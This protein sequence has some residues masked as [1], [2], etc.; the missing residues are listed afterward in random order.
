MALRFSVETDDTS[1]TYEIK[2][3]VVTVGR[4]RTSTLFVDDPTLSRTHCQIEIEA[5]EVFVRDLNSRNGTTVNGQKIARQRIKNGDRITIGNT[6]IVFLGP[7]EET[8][9]LADKGATARWTARLFDRKKKKSDAPKSRSQDET[10]E[11]VRRLHR[12]LAINKK[13]AAEVDSSRVLALILDS[14]VDFVN[15]ERGFLVTVDAQGLSIPVARDFWRKDVTGPAFEVSKSIA[16]EVVR[17]GEPLLTENASEDVRLEDMDSVHALQLRSVLCVPLKAQ[18][19]TIG[20][21]Y[22]DNRLT[23]G[24]FS[25]RDVAVLEAFADQAAI[26]L[27]N[28]GKLFRAFE[29]VEKLK[30]QADEKRRESAALR[31]QMRQLEKARGVDADFGAVLGRSPAMREFLGR[32]GDASTG[33]FP[34]LL[35]G[36]SGTGKHLLARGVHA[37]SP[38][39]DGPF[40][41]FS[42]AAP[43]DVV[44]AAVF[45]VEKR[46]GTREEAAGLLE[47]ADGGT[48][49]LFELERLDAD[50]QKRLLRFLESGETRRGGDVK[51]RKVDVRIVLGTSV[52]P[53]E[54]AEEG[55]LRE[56]L[57]LRFKGARHDVPPLRRRQG[58]I[59]VLARAFLAE[60][61]PPVGI[62]PR[63]LKSLAAYSW[64]RNVQELKEELQRAATLCDGVITPRDLAPHIAAPRGDD[65]EGGLKAHI[66]RVERDLIV[67]VLE[68][69]GDNKSQAAQILGLSRLGLRKKMARYGLM[70]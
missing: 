24:S 60:M 66:E 35:V 29:E 26:S 61:D 23:N 3:P 52:D 47:E 10:E 7:T 30:G 9:P 53:E 28:S 34:I 2:R 42:C 22:L 14:A 16:H 59:G 46:G 57:F 65:L 11:E 44:E 39:A 5:D 6:V 33:D 48:L 19:R 67:Q 43:K 4:S 36:E 62:T 32:L 38:R 50:L 31:A 54:S 27:V 70:K 51:W 45:G 58:D 8:S 40:A 1:H 63:A 56:D 17:R 20:A 21:L 18:G 37:N 68:R 49:Y 13:I 55:T 12:L 15:A 64:P 41:A 69:S 25:D